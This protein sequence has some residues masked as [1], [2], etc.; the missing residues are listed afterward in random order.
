MG[1]SSNFNTQSNPKIS[2]PHEY[3]IGRFVC[4]WSYF[5]LIHSFS[6]YF[7]SLLFLLL[8][9]S[10]S[11]F[12]VASEQALV[13]PTASNSTSTVASVPP[14]A[15]LLNNPFEIDTS[16]STSSHKHHNHSV[17]DP[18]LAVAV[19]VS[20]FLF[21][22]GLT[23]AIMACFPRFRLFNL[24][25]KQMTERVAAH[26]DEEEGRGNYRDN[27]GE[28]EGYY[29]AG[30]QKDVCPRRFT[31]G[32]MERFTSSFSS[33]IGSGGFSTVY[34]A[35]FPDSTL[36]A[37]KIH[38]S[39]ERLNRVYKQEMEILFGLQHD[40]IVK[41]LGYCDDREEGVLVFEY[42][43]NGNLQEKLH[44]QGEDSSNS[45]TVLPWKNRMAIAYQLA[46]AM[47]YLH[48]KCPLQIVHGDIKASNILLDDQFN[49]KLCDFGSAKMG[50]SSTVLPPS[51]SSRA[52][53]MIMG[54]PGYTDPHYL[55][56]GIASKKNDVYSFGVIVLELITG[57]EAFCSESGERLTSIA[58]PMLKD[59]S[60]VVE[61]MDPRLKLVDDD[62]R[63]FGFG[64]DLEEVVA[65]A[66]LAAMCLSDSATIR[67]SASDIVHRMR[68]QIP[69]VSALTSLS[70]MDNKKL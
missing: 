4:G 43:P 40:N 68:S 51:S 13:V 35:Q 23:F 15:S 26:D 56:T 63:V 3:R 27:H 14:P 41:F 47:E 49:C 70:S 59:E 34:L 18:K 57:L 32:E 64:F 42:V 31:W 37:I 22:A 69:S 9:A 39:S 66:S 2:I 10:L 38:S 36:G 45:T 19:G 44:K 12:L 52:N 50:F 61:M 65:M 24:R 55:R 33:V 20:L 60:K 8:W 58:G 16:S 21:F 67:P 11:S 46:Q 7:F 29:K 28:N 30:M 62:D 5:G 17:I 6:P 1:A 53:R 48:E 54:S 25:R